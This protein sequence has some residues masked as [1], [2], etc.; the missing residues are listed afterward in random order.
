[1]AE[2]IAKISI[3]I[4]GLFLAAYFVLNTFDGDFGWHLRF[5]QD[6]LRGNFPLTD[7]YTYT[8]FGEKWTNHEW[9][10]DILFASLYRYIGYTGLGLVIG[11]VIWLAFILSIKIF[12]KNITVLSLLVALAGMLSVKFLFAL[13]PTFFAALFFVLLWLALEKMNKKSIFVIP[14]ILWL[15]SA[16]HGSWILGF[17][18]VNIYLAGHLWSLFLSRRFLRFA[19]QQSQW[20]K[21]EYFAALGAEIFAAGLVCLNPYGPTIWAEVGQYFSGGYF[22]QIIN[23]WLPS[24]SYPVYAWPMIISAVAC[25]LFALGLY[26]KK[27]SWPQF[28]LFSALFLSAWLYKR[29]WIYPVLVSVPL[30]TAIL[31]AEFSKISSRSNRTKT[32]IYPAAAIIFAA[33]SIIC[34]IKIPKITNV[35]SDNAYLTARGYPARAITYLLADSEMELVDVFNEFSW[36]GLINA[37]ARNIRVYLDGRGTATWRDK[38]GTLLLARYRAIKYEAGGLKQITESSANYILLAKN[39]TGYPQPNW[40]NRIIF[41]PADFQ[42]LFSSEKPQLEKMLQKSDQWSLVYEDGL[43]LIWKRL[44]PLSPK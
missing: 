29:N 20:T 35:F 39:R 17:I 14:I 25:V 2:K 1:M 26:I 24:F 34:V 43:A 27:I 6:T 10:S 3:I 11:A 12:T 31:Q 28:L 4:A 36:G 40:I 8:Y 19:G 32:I 21:K 37:G 16:M 23:E 38:D 15:W 9:G 41:T 18:I 22:K 42:K 33:I 44:T 7:S 13:R 30:F 5:G